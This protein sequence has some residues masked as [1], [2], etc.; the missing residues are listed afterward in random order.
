MSTCRKKASESSLPNLTIVIATL[1]SAATI[2]KTLASVSQQNYPNEKI[3]LLIIDGKSG[4]ETIKIAQSYGARVIDNPK[5]EPGHAK[6]LGLI[7][8]TGEYITFLDSDETLDNINSIRNKVKLALNNPNIPIIMSQGYVT[9]TGYSFLTKYI[10][11]FGDPFSCF[12]YRL[13][14]SSDFFLQTMQKRYV[15]KEYA[16]DYLVCD[17]QKTNQLPFIEVTTMAS[18][19]NV[20]YLKKMHS[21][22]FEKSHL[23]PHA[24]YLITQKN[25]LLAIMK[26]DPI[27]H[28]SSTSLYAYIGKIRSRIRN[29]IHFAKDTGLSGYSGR[30]QFDSSTFKAKR[31]MFIPYSLLVFPAFLDSL[32]LIVSKRDVRYFMHLPL[33]FYTASNIVLEYVKYLLKIKQSRMSY[34]E[35]TSVNN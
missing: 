20:A 33:S 27:T 6:Y 10:N 4:D 7:N 9:P 24:F 11:E 19:M 15:V 34:G 25:P 21:E 26:H 5:I 14:K 16:P 22:L 31:F 3:E 28:Y 35:S 12:M 1:N 13:S 32:Y 23:I 18:L 8:A 2:E 17:I 29:N 30:S